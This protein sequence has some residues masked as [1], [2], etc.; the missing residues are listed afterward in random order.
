MRVEFLPAALD[1]ALDAIAYYDRI[2]VDLGNRFNLALWDAIEQ[3]LQA[4]DAWPSMGARAR[5]RN[6]NRFPYGVVYRTQ[7]DVVLIIAVA[8]LHRRPGY[9]RRRV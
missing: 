6:L 9:W 7:A 1:D 5:K 8:H 4:P 3:V 2:S